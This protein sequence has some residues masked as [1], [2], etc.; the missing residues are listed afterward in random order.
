MDAGS[1]GGSCADPAI[2][3]EA[4]RE[5]DQWKCRVIVVVRSPANIGVLRKNRMRGEGHGRRIIDLSSVCSSYLVSTDQVPRSPYPRT[6]I[7]VAVFPHGGAEQ[8]QQ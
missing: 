6:W 8:S 3:S 5:G 4:H 7:E 2:G 1:N